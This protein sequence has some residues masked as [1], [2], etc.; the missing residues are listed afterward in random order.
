MFSRYFRPCAHSPERQ[1]RWA[2]RSAVFTKPRGAETQWPGLPRQPVSPG[3]AAGTPNKRMLGLKCGGLT[4][5]CAIRAFRIRAAALRKQSTVRSK[6]AEFRVEAARLECPAAPGLRWGWFRPDTNGK[7][8][9]FSQR[10]VGRSASGT[11]GLTVSH[12]TV[13]A[14]R[15]IPASFGSTA[16]AGFGPSECVPYIHSTQHPFPKIQAT[17]LTAFFKSLPT[18]KIQTSITGQNLSKDSP[19]KKNVSGSVTRNPT[20][21]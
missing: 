1:S 21:V 3:V 8:F 13:A 12:E 14:R 15:I 5:A 20:H 6:P 2:Q 4:T 11:C 10:R 17:S 9:A 16:P 19:T 18:L 7:P